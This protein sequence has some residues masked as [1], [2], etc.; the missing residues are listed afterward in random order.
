VSN[1][2]VHQLDSR[3]STVC[4]YVSSDVRL[5]MHSVNDNAIEGTL[6]NP[7]SPNQRHASCFI[8]VTYNLHAVLVAFRDGVIKEL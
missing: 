7:V 3:L 4:N 5:T 8:V 6:F 1:S 2:V